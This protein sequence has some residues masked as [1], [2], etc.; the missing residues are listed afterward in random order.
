[1]RRNSLF[2]CRKNIQLFLY[3]IIAN[4]NNEFLQQQTLDRTTE[5]RVA[6]RQN[7]NNTFAQ[8]RNFTD[9]W[10][11]VQPFPASTNHYHKSFGKRIIY[12]CV[13]VRVYIC[14]YSIYI[15]VYVYYVSYIYVYKYTHTS[16]E[17]IN[18]FHRRTNPLFNIR[19]EV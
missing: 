3:V 2:P 11:T 6:L 12:L 19:I 14:I 18:Y 17:F 7:R 15:H 4:S 9:G 5:Q 13:C 10:K 16:R 8:L 1:M